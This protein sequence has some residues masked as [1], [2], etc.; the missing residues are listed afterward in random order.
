MNTGFLIIDTIMRALA[1]CLLILG[2]WIIFDEIVHYKGLE[3]RRSI[4]WALM[5]MLW[6]LWTMIE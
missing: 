5:V 3:S 4:S 6:I 1:V 2:A